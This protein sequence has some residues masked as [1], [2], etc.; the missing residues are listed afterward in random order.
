MYKK[1]KIK[2]APAMKR[3]KQTMQDKLDIVIDAVA[4]GKLGLPEIDKDKISQ[5]KAS[6]ESIPGGTNAVR[7]FTA[8]RACDPN[9]TRDRPS[10]ETRD[11]LGEE[12]NSLG[13]VED[14][15]FLNNKN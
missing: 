11:E 5:P 9:L 6:S 7:A 12:D 15:A 13:E 14:D 8:S 10:V 4:K 1:R 2:V 3:R